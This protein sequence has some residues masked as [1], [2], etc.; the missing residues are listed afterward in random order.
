MSVI[1]YAL[2][3][4]YVALGLGFV[5]FFHELGHFLVAKWNGVLVEKFSIGFGPALLRF[6]GKETQYVLAAFP[7]GGFVK[8]LGE[9]PEED[10]QTYDP[11]AYLHK[12][13]GARMA[14]IAA[15]PAM[16]I[17]LG[18]ACFC[19]AYGW[20]GLLETPA[21]LGLVV[22]GL[23]AYQAGVRAGDEV[24]AIDG[25][26]GVTFDDL[27]RTVALSG[28]GQVVHMEL[29]RPGQEAPVV[30]NIEPRREAKA[31]RPSIGV[32]PSLGLELESD[33]PFVPPPGITETP[34]EAMKGFKSGDKLVQVIPPG[35]PAQDVNDITALN[36][37]LARYAG[38]SL[39]FVVERGKDN[40]GGKHERV[41]VNVP[42]VRVVDFGFRLPIEPIAAV[43]GGSIAEKA[44][45]LKGDLIK[46][47][48]GATD[49]DPMRL[50]T[51][52]Y[53]RAGKPVVFEIER[54][55]SGGPAKTLSLTVTPENTPAWT[56]LVLPSEPLEVPGIGIAY[57]VSM[58]IVSVKADS[59]AARAGFKP[60]T[61][62]KTMAI[63]FTVPDKKDTKP[64]TFKF[65]GS[66]GWP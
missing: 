22:A 17:V 45:F 55:G 26:R 54:T 23:P 21:K 33:R 32:N 64:V 51:Y 63:R 59:P 41:T 53:E 38:V 11:R 37:L 7:L 43:Q 62:I 66:E 58:Q 29:K 9:S 3:I 49:F 8:M 16:N 34:A 13:V 20:G 48:D 25:R 10:A 35:E 47:V 42:P 15:G 30:V 4:L 39:G 60:G 1:S 12:P 18:L 46:A 24:V 14:I 36:A 52:C 56:E 65:D 40:A 28:S 57:R 6:R 31:E 5:I 61:V 27:L 50:P 44:G 2:N 19:W